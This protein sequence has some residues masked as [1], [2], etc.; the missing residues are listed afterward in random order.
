MG[1]GTFDGLHDGHRSYFKQLWELGDVVVIVI[2]RDSSVKK[3]K[4]RPAQR[5]ANERLDV[6]RES[7]L[8]TLA[9]LGNEGDFYQVI[10]DHKPQ[11]IGLGYDQKANVEQLSHHFPDIEVVRLKP[12]KPE[13]Y[14]S[15]LLG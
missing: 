2:A 9:V 12:H 3:I 13:M 5:S 11:V 10:R 1:F 8:V 14:K 4:G 7:E 15:S 6:V